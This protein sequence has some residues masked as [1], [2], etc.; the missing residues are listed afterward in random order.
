[1][2]ILNRLHALWHPSCFH[3]WGRNRRF[4][5]G[6]YY[7]IVN[8]DQSEAMAIIPG[9]AMDEK[10]QKQAF[11]QVLDGIRET[12]VYHRFDANEFVP[13][14]KTHSLRIGD[15][16]FTEQQMKL[17]L[18]ELKGE[19]FFDHLNPWSS[20][21]FSPGIMG[22][23]SFV[24]FMECYHGILSM[25]HKIRGGFTYQGKPITFE[26]GKGYIE[27]DWGHSFP[28][29]YMW[30]QTNHFS[31]EGISVKA[32]IAKIPWLGSSFIGHI[33]G[34][35][36][37]GQ[38]YEFTTYNG[39]RLIQCVISSDQVQVEMANRKYRLRLNAKREKST[40]L[41]APISGFMDGRIEESMK[42]EVEVEL[43]DK[44]TKTILLADTGTSGGIEVAGK[45]ELLTR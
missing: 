20:S 32:S 35:L 13:S 10:G 4:F 33:A 25:N 9:I 24:P 36:L 12:A 21:V 38:L 2:V 26:K 19:V 18:P 11:I 7:K 28:E 1:M 39:T 41:A 45:Y 6:W 40:A 15:N 37:N 29:A 14:P 30:M 34:V 44:I 16:F 23:F 3:G 22:P 17:A 31:E 43:Y 8:Q 42:A 27:K 5:E